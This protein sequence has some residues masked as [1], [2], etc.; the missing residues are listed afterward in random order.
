MLLGLGNE[1]DE[2]EE[3]NDEDE[4]VRARGCSWLQCVHVCVAVARRVA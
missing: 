3:D 1:S 2:G 4:E